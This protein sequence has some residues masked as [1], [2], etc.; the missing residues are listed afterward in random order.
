MGRTAH[1]VLLDVLQCWSTRSETVM[2]NTTGER[3]SVMSLESWVTQSNPKTNLTYHNTNA[4]V[5]SAVWGKA[6]SH[7]IIS[8]CTKQPS[9]H[10]TTN[11]SQLRSHYLESLIWNGLLRSDET[12]SSLMEIN[13]LHLKAITKSLFSNPLTGT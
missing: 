13:S 8:N 5:I 12:F 7:R 1:G 3:V 9:K 4:D 10:I 11:L 6:V 2:P